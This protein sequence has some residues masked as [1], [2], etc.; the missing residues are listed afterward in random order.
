MRSLKLAFVLALVGSTVA[1]G[2]PAVAAD[3]PGTVNISAKPNQDLVAVALSP[4]RVSW[5]DRTPKG[6][7]L[8]KRGA[9][10][11]GSQVVFGFGTVLGLTEPKSNGFLDDEFRGFSP[12]GASGSRTGWATETKAFYY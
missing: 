2:S 10:L 11:D 6:S 1:I 8:F 3:P 4:G 12:W 7:P 5:V 9:A